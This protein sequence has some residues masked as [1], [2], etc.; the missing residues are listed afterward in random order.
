MTEW[1]K[2]H[3]FS[4]LTNKIDNNVKNQKFKNFFENIQIYICWL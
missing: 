4:F 3:M 2:Y 1:M